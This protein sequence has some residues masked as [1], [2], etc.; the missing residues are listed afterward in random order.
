MRYY[1]HV[2]DGQLLLDEEGIEFDDMDAV[3]QEAVQSAADMLKGLRSG[4]FWTGEPWLLWVSDGPNGGGNTLLT[5]TVS[6]R[7]AG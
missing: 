5:L 1:F 7:L 3:K 6:S 2:K 4:H